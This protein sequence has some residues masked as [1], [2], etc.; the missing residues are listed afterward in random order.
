[1]IQAAYYWAGTER[2][3]PHIADT[4]GPPPTVPQR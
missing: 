4:I 2:M 1:M 3:E